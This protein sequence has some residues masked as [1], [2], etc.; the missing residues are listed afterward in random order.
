MARGSVSTPRSSNQDLRLGRRPA[1]CI[2]RSPFPTA[3]LRTGLE[4]RVG[5]Q[6]VTLAGTFPTASLRTDRD[7]FRVNQTLQLTSSHSVQVFVHLAPFPF[8]LPARLFPFALWTALPSSPVGRDSH[9]Y[10]GNSVALGLAPRR[11]SRVPSSGNVRER[12]RPPTQALQWDRFPSPSGP[13]VPPTERYLA[14]PSGA[15]T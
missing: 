6:R 7:R 11:R 5:G 3:P 9:D 8:Q 13:D 4:C 10:Y 15:G 12:R 1:R 14:A 2:S